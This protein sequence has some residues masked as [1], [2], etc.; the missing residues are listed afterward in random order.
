MNETAIYTIQSIVDIINQTGGIPLT[1]TQTT[2][3]N[4]FQFF[5]TIFAASIFTLFI[6]VKLL[7]EGL[8]KSLSHILL[9]LYLKRNG[10]KHFMVIK[11]TSSGIF[12]QSMINRSTLEKVQKALMKF[13]G[14]PFDL[15]L[16]TPGGEIFSATFISRLFKKYP[17][18]I[19]SIIPT[20]AMSGGTLLALSTDEIYMNDYSCLGAIDPQLGN[21]FR[22]GSAKSYKEILRIKGKKADDQTIAFKLM[23]EQYTKSIKEN[24]EELLKDKASKGNIKLLS[25]LMTSGELEHGFNMTKDFLRF[26]GL[27]IKDLDDKTGK[28][29]SKIIK[30]LP[31]GV[32]YT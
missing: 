17:G 28:R 2:T 10:I 15:V 11:H 16:Y 9:K 23:G 7:G 21:L 18:K 13:K 8:S 27:E 25:K 6:L 4:K 31:Q 3:T 26:N 5:I 19:R 14:K 29:I 32:T 20:F 22:Y 1:V 30:L 12:D 24:V